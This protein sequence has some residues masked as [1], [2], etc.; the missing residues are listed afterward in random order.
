MPAAPTPS[1]EEEEEEEKV[2]FSQPEYRPELEGV[3]YVMSQGLVFVPTHADRGDNGVAE[4]VWQDVEEEVEAVE[5][6]Q[7]I[8]DVEEA[9]EVEEVEVEEEVGKAAKRERPMRT[10]E[11]K[12]KEK[13]RFSNANKG[14]LLQYFKHT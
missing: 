5:E 4:E 1:G 10:P 8:V 12:K 14:S 2:V 7:E 3:S 11:P 9:D 6:V 13:Y